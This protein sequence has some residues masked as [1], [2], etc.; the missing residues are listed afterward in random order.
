MKTKITI[1]IASVAI[2]LSCASLLFSGC[3]DGVIRDGVVILDKLPGVTVSQVTGNGIEL[4][5][6]V[7]TPIAVGD[8]IISKVDKS[9]YPSGGILRRVTAVGQKGDTISAL[10]GPATLED[11]IESGALVSAFNFTPQNFTDAGATKASNMTLIDF[12]GKT[13]YRD[14]GIA[15]TVE[16]GTLDCAPDFFINATWA[17]H[18]LNTFDLSTNGTVV[19]TLDLKIAVDS[20]TPLVGEWDIIKP[21]YC[22]FATSIGPVPVY[23]H[24]ALTLPLGIV[25]KFAGDT[26]IQS[27]LDITNAFEI[28][29]HYGNGQWSDTVVDADN[30]TVDGHP[31]Q[32]NIDI[33]GEAMVYIKVN[34]ELSLYEAATAGLYVKPY[35]YS[36]IHVFP[37]PATID[38]YAGFDAGGTYALGI[39]GMNIVDG[40]YNWEGHRYQ[41]YA[42]SQEYSDPLPWTHGSVELW[43]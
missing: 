11:A 16:Q 28:N 39:L 34:L 40:G 35:L 9:V 43:K 19:L 41:L 3:P 38:V 17:N 33:G 12:S 7:D 25:G 14:N 36:N 2:V 29:A 30:F 31:L 26:S 8:I 20:E 5:S 10:T 18:R 22:P 24:V 4:T 23:G 27:G 42:D 32:W 15:I 21:I 6:K 13:I 1:A 37:S